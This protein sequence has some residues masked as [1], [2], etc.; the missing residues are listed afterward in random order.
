MPDL[1]LD[2]VVL[3]LLALAVLRGLFL[4]LV[5]ESFSLAALAAAVLAVRTLTDPAAAALVPFVGARLSPFALQVLAAVGVGAL[6]IAAVAITGRVVRRG[7]QAAG[8]GLADRVGGAGLG[9][10][11]GLLVAA[12]VLTG[13][14]AV[15]GR[16][17]PALTH[18][19]AFAEL[20]RV[21]HAV[22]TPEPARRD[23]A[24]PPRR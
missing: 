12:L 1:P 19:R 3:A 4:G 20:V 10:A 7:V 9:L 23:V 22:G 24:A 11:E 16:D 8:L 14:A 2:L 13:L 5:R 15:L 17:H 21:E 18:S 6:A